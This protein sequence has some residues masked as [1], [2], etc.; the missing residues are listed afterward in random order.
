[1]AKLVDLGDGSFRRGLVDAT[2][3]M[4]AIV[5]S[6]VLQKLNAGDRRLSLPRQPAAR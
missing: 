2:A 3:E 4:A 1:M 5:E 6:L